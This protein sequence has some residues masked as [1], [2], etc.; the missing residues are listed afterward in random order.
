MSLAINWVISGIAI[1]ITAYLLPGIHLSGFKAA[2][3]TAL[4]LGLI[5][6]FIKPVL[7]LLTLPLTVM[8][9]G[10]FSLVLNALLIMLTA[11]LVPGFQVQ[12]FLWAV[13]F[14]VVLTITNWIL[15]IFKQ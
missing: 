13:A 14:S 9:L 10:L 6:A 7:S 3:L 11:K 15:S 2:L 8:T 12:G 1:V 4:A 5:N